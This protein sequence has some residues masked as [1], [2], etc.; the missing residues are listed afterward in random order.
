MCRVGS[1]WRKNEPTPTL[2]V[3]RRKKRHHETPSNTPTLDDKGA[4]KKTRGK[5][6]SAQ[7]PPSHPPDPRSTLPFRGAPW[8]S[9][10]RSPRKGCPRP[11]G[12]AAAPAAAGGGCGLGPPAEA[13]WCR[14]RSR[15]PPA[16]KRPQHQR[17]KKGREKGDA[18]EG[19]G[20]VCVERA[21]I[22][23]GKRLVHVP[24]YKIRG[25]RA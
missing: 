12:S 24:T 11:A 9:A 21:K 4:Q 20:G 15:T 6:T 18:R 14:R 25:G 16:K 17:R 19:A 3:K 23:V 10:A 7:H 22:R 8:R 1:S 5:K 2:T 13:A